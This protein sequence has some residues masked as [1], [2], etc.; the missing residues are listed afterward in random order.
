MQAPGS[1]SPIRAVYCARAM[2]WLLSTLIV[3]LAAYSLGHYFCAL[4]FASVRRGERSFPSSSAAVSVLVPSRDEG[5]SA[6]RV[7]E[8]LLAQDHDGPLSIYLLV[9]DASDTSVPFLRSRFGVAL[10]TASPSC[11]EV[12]EQDGRKVFVAFTGADRKSTKLN[13]IA[14]H[15]ETPYVAVLDCDHRAHPLWIRSSLALLQEKSARIV[16]GLRGPLEVRGLFSLWDSLHQH[17]GCEL[18]NGAFMRLHLTVFCTGTTFVMETAL[19]RAHPFRDC[20][21]EDID[22]SYRLLLAGETIVSNPYAGSDEELS[23]NMYSF[24]ARRRRWAAGHTESFLRY[25]GQLRAAKLGLSHRLQF[26]LHGAHYLIAALVYILHLGIGTLF[27]ER[28]SMESRLAASLASLS[29]AMILVHTQ[30]TAQT[31][32]KLLETLVL[33]A[34]FFPAVAI[35]MNL[36]VA[37][38]LGDSSRCLLPLPT[39]IQLFALIGFFAPVFVLIIGLSKLGHL[40]LRTLLAVAFTYPVAFYL[41]LAGVLLGLTDFATGK[42]RWLAITRASQAPSSRTLS[43]PRIPASW[44]L[45][46]AAS[47]LFVYGVAHTPTT[48]VKVDDIDCT[49]RE[50]D[51]HPWIVP[52]TRANDYCLARSETRPPVFATRVGSFLETRRDTLS[53]I[54]PRYWDRLDT[55]FPC[56]EAVFAPENIETLPG[57]GIRLHLLRQAREDRRFTAASIATK[58]DRASQHLYGRFETIMKPIRASGVVS[59]FFLYRFDPWQE[60]DAEFPGNDTT[61]LLLNVYYNPGEEGDL[62]NYGFLGTPVVIDLG[63]DAAE[64]FHLYAIEWTEEEIRWFVDE[65]LVHRRSAGTPTPIPHLPMRFYVNVWPTCSEPLAGRLDEAA[66][67]GFAEIRSISISRW[68]PSPFDNLFPF[69]EGLFARDTDWRRTA[70]WIQPRR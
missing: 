54:D 34:W 69:F 68:V 56:N 23:P 4:V 26:L 38:L 3:L 57:E 19:M 25:A 67:P 32:F 44:G 70:D 8:S 17:V 37:F 60:I 48:R 20:I 15:I 52:T 64:D 1:S 43:S 16:Q 28:M 9:R 22:L 5:D 13:W 45:S 35:A 62:Y 30:R 59:A 61:K 53:S 24:L 31:R 65:R 18:A 40:R 10:D 55:T 50:H 63:F 27:V 47:I 2:V 58:T 46:L 39:S 14:A 7:I 66:L 12:H 6:R 33:F 11:V 49:L 29:I 36:L 42:Q 21:T 41:D 51:S